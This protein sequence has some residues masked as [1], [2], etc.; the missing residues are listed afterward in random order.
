EQVRVAPSSTITVTFNM[1]MDTASVEAATSLTE[2]GGSAATVDF[3]WADDNRVVVLD[4]VDMLPLETQ[5]TLTVASSAASANGAATMARDHTS[6]FTTVPFPAVSAT[7]PG[8][9][10][11]ADIWQR[12]FSVE[13]ASPMNDETVDGTFI[14]TPQP[15]DVDYFINEWEEGYS[16]YVDFALEPE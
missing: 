5:F 8:D 11:V 16:V 13:F 14:I 15:D 3:D 2:A 4:P 12:G 6:D 10:E 9:G 7:F 1:P